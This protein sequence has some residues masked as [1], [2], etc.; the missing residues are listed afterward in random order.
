MAR[1]RSP[2]I[3]FTLIELLV[4]IAIIAIL[5]SILFPVF[6]RAREKARQTSCLSNLKQL[7]LALDMYVQDYDEALVFGWMPLQSYWYRTA[8]VPYVRNSQIFICP[9][10][11]RGECGYGYSRPHLP[12][13]SRTDPLLCIG[14]INRPSEV[15]WL[16]DSEGNPDP[17][18]YWVY[19]PVEYPGM[20]NGYG[21][22]ADRHNGGAN[23]AFLD[24]H[25][26]WMKR[27]KIVETD[28]AAQI[29]WFHIN[30]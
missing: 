17:T 6:S 22:V 13:D 24:G 23:Q 11:K 10:E 7:A 26:K 8:I 21:A 1:R 12:C 4:V 20:Q 16:C 14:E 28:T 25:A 2:A 9:S 18:W 30:P 5:A 3:G 15:M 29:R 27:E 19:C